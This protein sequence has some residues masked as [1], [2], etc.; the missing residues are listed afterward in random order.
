MFKILE[1]QSQS[2]VSAALILAA[3]SLVSRFLGL[4]RDRLLAANFGA[5]DTLDVY[6]AAFQIPDLAFNLLVVGALSAGFIPIFA[7]FW[8]KGADKKE[9][10]RFVNSLFNIILLALILFGALFI[11]F[12]PQVMKLIVPG[13]EGEKFRQ[14][15]FLARIMFLS[16]VFLGASTVFGGVLQ[17][18][19]RF[20]VIALT[21]VLYNLGII[22]GIIFLVPRFGILGLALGVAGGA[23]VHMAIQIPSMRSLG[24]RYRAT[25]DWGN[26]GL[27]RLSK[28][29]IPRILTLGVSQINFL[30]I[31]VI[32]STLAAGSLAI[33]NF[34]YNIWNFPLGI[35]AA[36]FA[37]AAF[38]NLAENAAAKNWR[39]YSRVFSAT[40]RQIIFLIIP[41]SALFLVLRA[42]IV[43]V[44]LGAGKFD[45]QDTVLTLETLQFL[46][47]GLFAEGLNLLVARSFFAL[48]D[49]KT[50]F[51][52][53][54]ASSVFR[55]FGA[56]FFSAKMGV[57]GL[58]FGY[59]LGG[60]IYFIL[61]LAF[62]SRRVDLRIKEISLSAAKIVPASLAGGIT[63]FFSLRIFDGFL[64]TGTLVGIFT[65]GFL[66][67]I[68]GIIIYLAICY[69]LRSP[70]LN[71]ILQGFKKK[72]PAGSAVADKEL[73]Q[74]MEEG[75]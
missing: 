25:I 52:L 33:F 32:A 17:G 22:F 16:P 53:G 24:F 36:S 13:F 5:G 38:P 46:T 65:Q 49:T 14:T 56:L 61:L 15:V 6:Y 55:I 12:A 63:A 58:A 47:L 41:A 59:A 29:M 27:R 68:A 64:N 60:I 34:A 1:K 4:L 23:F 57:A 48:E 8:Q 67:G 50:P 3:A 35:L 18:T 45:W 74:P 9:A 54:A 37:M 21:S 10:W 51:F 20:F 66:A 69:L 30:A 2:V 62:L 26:H 42:Q 7:G 43:R 73:I 70:E 72:I 40:F 75:K 11:I 71:D 39:Q 28:L 31:T 19:K 44:V